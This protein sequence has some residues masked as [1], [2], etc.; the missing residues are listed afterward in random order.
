VI[1]ALHPGMILQPG[2][3][4]WLGRAAADIFEDVL[5]GLVPGL[6]A[7]RTRR[8]GV[9]A[10]ASA[11]AAWISLPFLV[12]ADTLLSAHPGAVLT[13]LGT[14]TGDWDEPVDPGLTVYALLTG[15]M[16]ALL[17]ARRSSRPRVALLIAACFAAPAALLVVLGAHY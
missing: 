17:L 7:L 6:V 5:L 8:L 10:A 2:F 9:L 11:A 14:A 12:M 3:L 16:V 15:A 1:L 4:L 13:A